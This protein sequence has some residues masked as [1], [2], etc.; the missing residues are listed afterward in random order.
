MADVSHKNNFL[1]LCYLTE[2]KQL[3]L[4]ND[5]TTD[6]YYSSHPW[7]RMQMRPESIAKHSRKML[8]GK[9]QQLPQIHILNKTDPALKEHLDNTI[10]I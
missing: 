3:Y 1:S 8:L 6:L 5:T 9:E 7:L 4:C 10:D 2:L